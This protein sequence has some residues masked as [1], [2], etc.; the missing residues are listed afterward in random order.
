[1]SLSFY[2]VEEGNEKQES[3]NNYY[4]LFIDCM[5]KPPNLYEAL[6]Q[7]FTSAGANENEINDLIQDIL[8]KSENKI[9]TTFKE[10]KNK[11]PQI[12]KEDAI[13][14]S[15]YTCES[16]K[17]GFSPYQLLNTNMVLRMLNVYPL[18]MVPL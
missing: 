15:S 4:D 18:I 11:F 2:D 9:N 7:M 12:S 1:M 13:I 14:I 6:E 5:I 16:K 8:S 3:I 17:E 10:I